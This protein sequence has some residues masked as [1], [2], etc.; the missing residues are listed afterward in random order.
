M[1]KIVASIACCMVLLAPALPL[2]AEEE[3]PFREYR[4]DEPVPERL[5]ETFARFAK[6]AKSGSVVSYLLP[7]AVEQTTGR[8]PESSREY[9]QNIN[10]D[11]LQ[12]HFQ[13]MVQTFRKD[14][15]DCYLIRTSTSAIWWVQTKSGEWR[16]Y[17]YLDKP[18]R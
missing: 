5:R 10:A 2:A 1:N 4:G 9:G 8:R 6:A 18:I 13:G 16:V 11:F 17:R 7:H 12:N 15:D 3:D 14:F